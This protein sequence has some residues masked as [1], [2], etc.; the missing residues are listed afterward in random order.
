MN[1][2]DL[3]ILEGMIRMGITPVVTTEQPAPVEAPPQVQ[4]VIE[5][6][7]APAEALPAPAPVSSQAEPVDPP[8]MRPDWEK[9]IDD[10]IAKS[11]GRLEIRLQ[12]GA[13]IRVVAEPKAVEGAIEVSYE[14]FK[15]LS[16]AAAIL[17]A[18]VVDMKTKAVADAETKALLE[19]GSG[20]WATPHIFVEVDKQTQI[21]G[22]RPADFSVIAPPKQ[23]PSTPAVIPHLW[24][25]L[26]A[27]SITEQVPMRIT[28]NK[29]IGTLIKT[30]SGP[31]YART[32]K[33][34][35]HKLNIHTSWAV[36]GGYTIERDAYDKY[37]TDPATVIKFVRGEHIYFTTSNWIQRYGGLIRHWGTER[38]VMPL[39]GGYW[40]VV[41]RNGEPVR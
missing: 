5:T 16:R 11:G 40:L 39:S 1:D 25:A 9:E 12:S 32:V 18:K 13:L 29:V 17:N 23:P 24:L 28:G 8:E 6:T 19:S 22:G 34:T 33:E 2:M 38:V 3:K 20:Y 36:S 26:S 21:G 41:D 15:R 35:E 30:T 4:P 31:L 27:A 14:T 7:A 37:L 10:M